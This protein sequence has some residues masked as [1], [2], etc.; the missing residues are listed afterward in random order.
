MKVFFKWVFS[1][2]N[3]VSGHKPD[4]RLDAFDE[5]FSKEENFASDC[6]T[7]SVLLIQFYLHH[8]NPQVNC[9]ADVINCL[10]DFGANVN[11]L[12]TEGLS[13]LAACYVLQYTKQ[14]FIENTAEAI[15]KENT[16]NSIE[17]DKQ[18]GSMIH[19]NDRKAIL[20][21]YGTS[22][23]QSNERLRG[24]D[25]RNVSSKSTRGIVNEF[26]IKE[27]LYP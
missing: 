3:R 12:N 15:S 2:F 1:F 19:R 23:S 16:F 21:M 17:W 25:G 20:S 6:T 26:V 27:T 14:D 5:A 4:H 11:I 10:L 13:P 7:V 9:H 18:R 22:R 24:K 8:E